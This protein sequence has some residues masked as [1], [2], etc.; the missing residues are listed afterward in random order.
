MSFLAV[1]QKTIDLWPEVRPRSATVGC[2][3]TMMPPPEIVTGKPGLS[4]GGIGDC[5]RAVP[6]ASVDKVASVAKAA[7]AASTAGAAGRWYCDRCR[8]RRWCRKEERISRAS[9]EVA[10]DVDQ[11]VRGAGAAAHEHREVVGGA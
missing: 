10:G 5:A 3:P 8:K 9:H 11:H 1:V 4:G 2:P 7:S 6:G